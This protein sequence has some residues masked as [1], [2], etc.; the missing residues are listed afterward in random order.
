MVGQTPY[1]KKKEKTPLPSVQPEV[2]YK[3]LTNSLTKPSLHLHTENTITVFL[4]ESDVVISK[5]K[6]HYSSF[7]RKCV[8]YAY[9]VW[10]QQ[11]THNVY[12]GLHCQPLIL[13]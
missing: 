10:L 11:A 3:K 13:T 6:L 12:V 5:N 1:L 7:I 4:M 2:V 9:A 8:G